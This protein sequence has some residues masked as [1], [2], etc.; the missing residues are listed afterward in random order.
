[1][2]KLREN[3]VKGDKFRYCYFEVLFFMRSIA[4][5]KSSEETKPGLQ[6]PIESFAWQ[7]RLSMCVTFESMTLVEGCWEANYKLEGGEGT[8]VILK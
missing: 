4:P 6:A 7:N 2:L 8:R 5:V 3:P 1:M